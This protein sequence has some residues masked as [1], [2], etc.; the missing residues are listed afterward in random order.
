[1][2]AHRGASVPAFVCEHGAVA[3][4]ARDRSAAPRAWV[5]PA[6]DGVALVA[7]TVVGVA[8]HDHG[9]PLGA[10]ARVGVPMLLAWF[11]AAWLVGAYR[12][13][14]ARTLVLA[15]GLAVPVAVLVRT[16]VAAGPWGG[17]LVVFLGVTLAF[18]LLFLLLVRGA[19][20][21]FGLDRPVVD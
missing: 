11:A 9:L 10:L 7:F 13:P 16:L 12:A 17:E 1:M 20:R 8:T 6:L 14:G 2:D 15:W 3:S 5:L 4:F 19:A 18:T 21:A